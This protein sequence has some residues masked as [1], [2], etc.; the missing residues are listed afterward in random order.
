MSQEEKQLLLKDLCA[1]LPHKLH[2]CV[3]KL[4][5]DIKEN[6]DILYGV[7]GDSVVTLKSNKDECLMYYQIKPYLRPMSSM[8]DKEIADAI[9]YIYNTDKVIYT[10]NGDDGFGFYAEMENGTRIRF[11]EI[12]FKLGYYGPK[13]IDWLNKYHFDYRGLIPMGLALPTTKGIY[14]IEPTSI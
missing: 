6:D 14:K 2:C 13:G 7:I 1:R 9:K 11:N 3:F 4:N 5:G 12:E 8:T 10:S